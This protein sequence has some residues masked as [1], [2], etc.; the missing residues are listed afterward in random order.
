MKINFRAIQSLGLGV[1]VPAASIAAATTFALSSPAKAE[2]PGVLEGKPIVE[3]RLEL[4][5]LRFQISPHAGISVAQPYVHFVEAG[6]KIQFDIADWLGIRAGFGYSIAK[7]ETELTAKV[8]GKGDGDRPILPEGVDDPRE[9]DRG[10]TEPGHN[11]FIFDN[12][13]P[14]PLLHDFKA[15]LTYMQ[16]QTS[17][18]IVFTPFSGKLGLFSGIFT[19]Y[20][21]YIFGG[22]GVVNWAPMYP[23]TKST[24]EQ[25]GTDQAE[26]VIDKDTGLP[27]AGQQFCIDPETNSQNSDC[28]LH[29]VKQDNGIR[30]GGSM[31]AGIHIFVSDW[32]SINP[33]IQDII[34][35]HNDTGLNKTREIY[36][37]VQ[38]DN[39]AGTDRKVRHNL[40]FRLGLNFYFPPKAKRST[41]KP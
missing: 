14:A 37:I 11:R 24:A 25:I 22:F 23:G 35:R 40:T 2:K 29:P 26:D 27:Q 17:A 41:L 39:L 9:Q 19:E 7:F 15:G 18:D 6:A 36:P 30:M 38:N 31:G 4:R 28:V 34:V 33:E 32:F 13:N 1:S 8:V 16:W 10:A 20:D 21:L 3:R 12:N 5:K